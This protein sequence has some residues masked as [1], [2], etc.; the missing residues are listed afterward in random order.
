M[1]DTK[2]ST[3]ARR[4]RKIDKVDEEWLKDKLSDDGVIYIHTYIHTYI[5]SSN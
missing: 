4:F 5:C 1:S 3:I 2:Y